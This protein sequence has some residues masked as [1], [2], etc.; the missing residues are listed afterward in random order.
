MADEV[1]LV[2]VGQVKKRELGPSLRAVNRRELLYAKIR[3]PEPSSMQ[4]IV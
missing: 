1:M 4:R 2:G 3:M